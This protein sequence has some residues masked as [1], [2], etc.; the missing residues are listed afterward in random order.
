MFEKTITLGDKLTIIQ[1]GK[2]S[3]GQKKEYV[4]KVLDLKGEDEVHIGM[5][6]EQSKEV[7]LITGAIYQLCVYTKRGLI[8]CTGK[9]EDSYTEG[10]LSIGVLKLQEEYKREQRRQYYRLFEKMEARYRVYSEENLDFD[11]EACETW[12]RA[13][14]TDISGG[15][16]R[17]HSKEQLEAGSEL[18]LK[19]RLCTS[20][21]TQIVKLLSDVISSIQI[22]NSDSMFET[23][24]EFSKIDIIQREQI[25]KYVFEEE[26]KQL[27]REKG[28][29]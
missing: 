29:M 1:Q 19:V 13:I 22:E 28:L 17:F 11:Q 2:D 24:V 10:N 25:I 4:S 12:K 15:G 7:N 6:L 16:A 9:V 23:R 14:L 26:R 5:P 18:I 20:S 27:R 8:N 3:E 21:N